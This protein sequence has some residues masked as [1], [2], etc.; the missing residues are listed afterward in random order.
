MKNAWFQ[1]AVFVSICWPSAGDSAQ[2]DIPRLDIPRLNIPRSEHPRPDFQRDQ[3]VN[4]NGH[5]QFRF[6]PDDQGVQQKWQS[7]AHGFDRRIVVPFCWESKLSGIADTSGQKIG[8]YRRTIRVPEAWGERR[9]WLRFGAVDWEARVWVDGQEVGSHQGG[10]TPFA[11][12]IT[13][14]A[15][16]GSEAVVVVRAVD[17]TD[18]ELPLG[19]QVSTWYT[20]TSGIWQTVWLEARPV[21]HLEQLRLTPHRR[22]GQWSIEA[23]LQ[24]T[25]P[26]GKVQ[27]EL[28]SSD[29]DV[30]GHRSTV[31]L[32]EGQGTV[33]AP[34][35]ISSA[36][37]WTPD[38][39]RLYD[40]TIRV[41]DAAGATDTVRT[42]FGLRTIETGTFGDL[43]HRL[44]LLNGEPIYLRGAL[45]QSFHPDGIYTAPSDDVM[46]RDMEIAKEA[47]LNFLRIHIKS[48]EPRRLYW[49][50]RT[51][52]LIMEDMPCAF[53][54]SA[55]GREAWEAT[56]RAT[57]RRDYNHPAIIAW[58]LFNETW[59]L[60]REAYKTDRDMQDWVLQMWTQVKE[61]LDPTRL[62][63]DNSPNRHDHVK[64]DINSWHFYID[65]YRRAR[66]HIENVVKN[67]R[68]GSPFNYVPGRQQRGMPLINSEYGAVAARGG[69]RDISW[70][71]RHL[72][73]QLRRHERIGG[74]V[75]TELSDI[76]WE[77]NGLV[78]YDRSAKE[79]GYGAFVP[80][81]TVADLQGA[82]FVGAD[83]PPAMEVAPGSQ[84]TVSV[85][86][87]H[88][89]RR[90]IAPTL[91]WQIVGTDNLGRPVDAAAE[92][93]RVVWDRCRVTFQKPLVI[94]IPAGRPFVGAL[95]LELIDESGKRIAANFINLISRQLASTDL[96][97]DQLD[98]SQQGPRVEVLGARLAAVRFDPAEFAA[99]RT[100]ELGWDWLEDR[101]KFYAYGKC[102]VEYHLAL[103]RFIREALPSQIVL[104]AE[105][106]TKADD[107]RLDWP[108]VRQPLDYPQTQERKYPGK[109]TAALLGRDLWQFA[110]ADDPADSRGVLSHHARYHHG[111]YG[112]LVRKRADLTKY[113]DDREALRSKPFVSLTFRT[114][115]GCG[116]SIYSRRL[117]RYPVDPTLII[118]TARDMARPAGWT[119]HQT[120][121]IHRLLDGSR[122]VQGIQI[123]KEG[124]HEWQFTTERPAEDWTA[125]ALDDSSWKTGTAGFGKSGLAGI[126]V[127][128]PW[129][130]PDLWLR[131]EIE[132]PDAPVGIVWQYVADEQLEIFVNGKPVSRLPD[133]RRDYR[134]R[135]LRKAEMELF[136]SGRNTIAVHCRNSRG[137][138][139]F[140]LGIRWIEIKQEED[141]SPE[142]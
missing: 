64:T 37:P 16:P 104:M 80:G 38:S 90:T 89:S 48:E 28:S 71:F 84:F 119:S 4:L 106:A 70:G 67:T 102:E 5:W 93:R 112:E 20:S 52:V 138:G 10:Y 139:T 107:Q 103:P 131:T 68:A 33:R 19:K 7:A 35:D 97:E 122:V 113:P 2:T 30:P 111:S 120:V 128:T 126:R 44:I 25:G 42:Y 108:A 66:E 132:L 60:G 47:G 99:F 58:C 65:D 125:V 88:F 82:D 57:I 96:D 133:S 53:A 62:V 114:E 75:Y 78:N 105:M 14:Q 142:E 85:F 23:D 77:H 118:Q 72:T 136:Q 73:T 26:D 109:V 91:R 98:N 86:V 92:T 121:T 51:G 74:Y 49:A 134:Q 8:W 141:V 40:L 50:D 45:D 83:A 101:G 29:A 87:S 63:E 18:P 116:M 17:E 54:P 129:T 123:G 24:I 22:G 115:D 31:R 11:I 13:E 127:H 61:E 39:P 46:R 130:A 9:V 95:T 32:K 94:R 43:T 124:G 100:D 41:T 55:R 137:R 21:C 59:G 12:D 117:G 110:L 79:F 69:D 36:E 1:M 6:D 15:A 27:V 140:D 135:P 76:E 56:M 34:M 3:W 81:M